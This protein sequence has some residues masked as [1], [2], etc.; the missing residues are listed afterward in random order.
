MNKTM[1]LIFGISVCSFCLTGY[2]T[3]ATLD[4]S[5]AELN[6]EYIQVEKSD[7]AL[8]K[9]NNP[10]LSL[11]KKSE[12]SEHIGT[13]ATGN[14]SNWSES[15]STFFFD[16]HLDFES[17]IETFWSLNRFNPDRGWFYGENDSTQ[18]AHVTDIEDICEIN[19]ASEFSYV[20]WAVGPVNEGDFVFFH[21]LDTDYYAAFKLNDISGDDFPTAAANVTWYLQEN[22]TANFDCASTVFELS[23]PSGVYVST[24]KFDLSLIIESVTDLT[25]VDVY[26]TLNGTDVSER[27]RSCRYKGYLIADRTTKVG[28]TIRCPNISARNLDVGDNEFNVTLT[29]SNGSTVSK[30]VNWEVKENIE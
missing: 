20:D 17:R 5:R 1:K 8:I 25:V 18:I 9:E 30:I 24:Q 19:D 28:T 13:I 26:A 15:S 3:A 2:V 14:I 22:G 11:I 6:G 7:R 29:M 12:A 21:N 16:D 27:V 4:N 10:Q 23:P